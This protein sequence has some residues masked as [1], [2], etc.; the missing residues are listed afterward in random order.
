LANTPQREIVDPPVSW[1]AQG[2]IRFSHFAEPLDGRSFTR[3][4]MIPSREIS[5]S[6]SDRL[7]VGIKRNSENVVVVHDALP[8]G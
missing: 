2:V 6:A 3:V 5:E 7:L 4:R 8:S 1:I